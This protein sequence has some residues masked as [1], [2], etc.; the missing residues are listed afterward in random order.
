MRL[1]KVW[2]TS[3]GKKS[4]SP[5]LS[6][7]QTATMATLLPRDNMGHLL[8]DA[9]PEMEARAA[10]LAA[11]NPELGEEWAVTEALDEMHIYRP[12]CRDWLWNAHSVIRQQ[13]AK[14]N[15]Y[16]LKNM[17]A[18]QGRTPNNSAQCPTNGVHYRCILCHKPTVL[19]AT[20]NFAKCPDCNGDAM[21]K[22][23][24][25]GDVFWC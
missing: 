4:K 8:G 6:E 1:S 5:R 19:A 2:R 25:E 20:M 13:I 11:E 16:Y 15:A 18:L 22:R 12:C 9:R 14:S 17:D 3:Q 24:A 21:S 7:P 23:K 10:R